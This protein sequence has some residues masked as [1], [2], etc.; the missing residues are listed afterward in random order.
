MALSQVCTLSLVF[1]TLQQSLV[2]AAC[3]AG[4]EGTEASSLAASLLGS[5]GDSFPKA[6][7]GLRLYP[8]PGISF[9]PA[10]QVPEPAAGMAERVELRHCRRCQC[11]HSGLHP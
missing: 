1:P 10:E 8:P 6:G 4:L 5:C 11:A 3:L 9:G 7:Q 2:C